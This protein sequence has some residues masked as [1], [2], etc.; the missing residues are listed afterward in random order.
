MVEGISHFLL[1]IFQ[2]SWRCQIPGFPASY[3]T[4]AQENELDTANIPD[5][6]LGIND[7]NIQFSGNIQSQ[8]AAVEDA[9]WASVPRG[10]NSSV[11]PGAEL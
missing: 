11:Q 7:S 2:R 1:P 10:S 6:E 5:F 3:V 9:S 4:Q 8:A